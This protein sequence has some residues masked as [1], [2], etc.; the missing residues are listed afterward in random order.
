MGP[1]RRDLQT[2]STQLRP[3]F[4]ASP[5]SILGRPRF[6]RDASS[7]R[8]E[9]LHAGARLTDVHPRDL[10]QHFRIGVKSRHPPDERRSRAH[11]R[12]A[13]GPA[14]RFPFQRVLRSRDPRAPAR[15]R[16]SNCAAARK[17][18]ETYPRTCLTAIQ[19]ANRDRDRTLKFRLSSIGPIPRAGADPAPRQH[20]AP[21][22]NR[23]AA[24]SPIVG[25]K[26]IK[27]AG[28]TRMMR[29]PRPRGPHPARHRRGSN[30]R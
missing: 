28:P 30:S 14:P 1:R 27:G 9:R 13:Q 29:G 22:R 8:T 10:A 2:P 11:L 17:R 18:P 15:S 6:F 4:T 19:S 24:I 21:L 26:T 23:V 20:S 5:G 25:G 7:Y 16:R 3:T 12:Q